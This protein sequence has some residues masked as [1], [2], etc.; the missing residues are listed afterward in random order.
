MA[1]ILDLPN[2][3]L[4]MIF[5]YLVTFKLGSLAHR[6]TRMLWERLTASTLRLVCR[7]W[8]E[9]FYIHHLYKAWRF[10]REEDSNRQNEFVNHLSKLSSSSLRPKCQVLHLHHLRNPIP[11][12]QLRSRRSTTDKKEG[13]S[14]SACEILEC[15]ADLFSDSLTEI[16]LRFK[17]FVSL[18]VQTL[19][20][21]GRIKNL[22]ILR[23]GLHRSRKAI[24][25]KN[26]PD[27]HCLRS[28]IVAAQNLKTLDLVHLNPV[29][30]T[31]T[32]GNALA[33][34]QLPAITQLDIADPWEGSCVGLASLATA[35]KSSIKMLSVSGFSPD[36]A[37]KIKPLFEVLKDTIEGISV[38]TS[39]TLGQVLSLKFPKLRVLEIQDW[40]RPLC[41]LWTENILPYGPI[42]VFATG[43]KPAHYQFP[44]ES[45]L[46]TYMP[47]LRR[48]VF[49][50]CACCN[51]QSIPDN[52]L[53]ACKAHGIECLKFGPG[54]RISEMM[55]L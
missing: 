49:P 3:V 6:Y 51:K 21:I 48:L 42:E 18:P 24:G 55:E 28:L 29:V 47:K 2:E 17:E 7:R 33:N 11:Y 40:D 9:W 27:S 16:E 20:A 10:V 5:E 41:D 53:A 39:S 35:L 8:A 43:I 38:E 45:D 31:S 4:D 44:L 30:L 37:Q 46:F 1:T 34:H 36:N 13:R 50:L 23:L 52:Y 26:R 22:R 54:L 32:V 25:A 15:L 14:R 19:E 12:Y